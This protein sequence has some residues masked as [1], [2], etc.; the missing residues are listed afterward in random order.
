MTERVRQDLLHGDWLSRLPHYLFVPDLIKGRRV[1]ELGCGEG[2]SAHYLATHGAATV[3]GVDESATNIQHARSTYR[4][5][6]LSFHACP[7]DAVQ[8]E[9]ASFDTILL[10]GTGRELRRSG[11]LQELRRLLAPNGTLICSVASADRPAVSSGVAYFE[12]VERLAPLFSP[13]RIAAQSP[14]IGVSLVEFD[15]PPDPDVELET[16]LLDVT[17]AD[18]EEVTHYLAICGGEADADALRG[19][20]IVQLPSLLGHDILAAQMGTDGAPTQRVV[21][22]ADGESALRAQLTAAGDA[23]DRALRQLAEAEIELNKAQVEIARV[24]GDASL[25]VSQ[26]RTQVGELLDKIAMLEEQLELSSIGADPDEDSEEEESNTADEWPP[27]PVEPVAGEFKTG[28]TVPTV[29]GQVIAAMAVHAER[30]SDLELSLEE[31]QAYIDELRDQLAREK[32]ASSEL[33]E[34]AAAA[35]TRVED[36]RAELNDWRS[37][38]SKSA[39][40]VLRLRNSGAAGEPEEPVDSAQSANALAALEQERDEAVAKLSR[41]TENWKSAEAKSDE[42]WRKVGELQNQLEAHR[43]TSQ[44]AAKKARSQ[45]QIA[46]AKAMEDASKRLITVQD[47]LLKAERQRDQFKAQVDELQSQLATPD[48]GA[49]EAVAMSELTSLRVAVSQLEE[50]LAGS[51]T[52]LRTLEAGV[53]KLVAAR[54]A[55]LPASDL[56]LQLGIRDAELTLMN[57]G[58]ASLQQRLKSMA[59]QVDR[60]RKDM[61]GQEPAEMLAIVSKLAE[62]LANGAGG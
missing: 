61:D 31:R 46:L 4:L 22:S 7:A 38:A 56:A 49:S 62:A 51:R 55:G 32:D 18:D 36:M 60:A 17:S 53:K 54:P 5:S 58:I 42:V 39:G 16:S 29:S 21:A 41:A 25:E 13:V 48:E 47:Q 26:A 40:E 45:H 9:D 14:F 12:L 50:E 27:P 44:D 35:E 3:V 6:N 15:G 43:E 2:H 57:V 33:S 52:L 23:R 11:V 34:R 10:W 20:T 8:L 37:R 19:F 24:A 59:S 28:P 1:L 30:V